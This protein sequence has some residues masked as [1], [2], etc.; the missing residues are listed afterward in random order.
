MIYQGKYP[1][2]WSN[3]QPMN[4]NSTALFQ[5]TPLNTTSNEYIFAERVFYKS[6]E[7]DEYRVLYVSVFSD[8]I[9]ENRLILI[10]LNE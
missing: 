3:K 2:F 1:S 9:Q 4:N 7:K 10:R 8:F 6:V 5:T